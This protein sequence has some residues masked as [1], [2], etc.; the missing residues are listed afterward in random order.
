M[1]LLSDIIDAEP[2]SYEEVS[3]KKGKESTSSRRMMSRMRYRDLR[4]VRSIF[5]MDLQDIG[6]SIWHHRGIQGKIHST[7]LL[8]EEG[9]DY[10]E[11]FA[12]SWS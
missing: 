12:S 10:E 4:E 7:R 5:H 9:I 1:T 6:C 11:K 2:S 3:K 8:T